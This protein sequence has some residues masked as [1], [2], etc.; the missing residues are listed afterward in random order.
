MAMP[1][2]ARPTA[3]QPTGEQPTVT[4]APATRRSGLWQGRIPAHLG[5]AR[6]S[7]VV[8]GCL[9]VLLFALH[10]M[11]RPDP[12]EYTSVTDANTGAVIQ[13]PA[14]LVPSAPAPSAPAPTPAPSSTVEEA[15]R[16]PSAPA[17]DRK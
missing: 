4:T 7:T 17:T 14:S 15:P 1:P 13:V 9:F 11:V 12:V 8:I 3:V 5:R 2:D 16:S 10:V 6:T